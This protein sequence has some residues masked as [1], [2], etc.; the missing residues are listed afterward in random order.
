MLRIISKCKDLVADPESPFSFDT[1]KEWWVPIIVVLVVLILVLIIAGL[2]RKPKIDLYKA[3]KE[4]KRFF[5][6]RRKKKKVKRKRKK[7]IW[8][9]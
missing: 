7:D 4:R 8:E 5:N 9:K 1:V 3:K 2:I 6:F